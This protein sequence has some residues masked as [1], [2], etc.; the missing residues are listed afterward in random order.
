MGLMMGHYLPR[1]EIGICTS[2]PRQIHAKDIRS[3]QTSFCIT[4]R[5]DS[6]LRRPLPNSFLDVPHRYVFHFFSEVQQK[7][8]VEPSVAE[9]NDS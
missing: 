6:P 2:E 7:K 5:E 9:V 3:A 1:A 4:K 8:P